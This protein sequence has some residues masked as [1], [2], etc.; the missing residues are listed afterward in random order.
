MR[1][2]YFLLKSISVV[3]NL[4]EQEI[5]VAAGNQEGINGVDVGIAALS[6]GILEG[7]GGAFNKYVEKSS[8]KAIEKIGQYYS[9]KSVKNAIKLDIKAGLKQQG[10]P[11]NKAEL[12]KFTNQRI[13]DFEKIDKQGIR[14]KS[15]IIRNGITPAVTN[16]AESGVNNELK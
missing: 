16:A 6:G 8:G 5:N 3:D 2:Y 13:S 10:M 14:T 9:D 12:S 15:D 4:R 7:A 1:R 11:T